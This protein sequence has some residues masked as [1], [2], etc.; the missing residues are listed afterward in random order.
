[1]ADSTNRDYA[2]ALIVL[3]SIYGG[4]RQLE[5]LGSLCEEYGFF[6]AFP[7]LAAAF[8]AAY[9]F[10][11]EYGEL[12]TAEILRR[13]LEILGREKGLAE[14]HLQS[15]VTQA[16]EWLG[17]RI[18]NDG[19][20][21]DILKAFRE[22][23]VC[24]KLRDDLDNEHLQKAVEGAARAIRSDPFQ[25]PQEENPFSNPG[26]YLA[27]TKPYPFGVSFLDLAMNGG[28]QLGETI[29]LVAPSGGGK[30]TIGLQIVERQVYEEQHVVYFATEQK[31]KGDLALRTFVLATGMTRADWS[32]DWNNIQPKARE[33]WERVREPWMKYFHFYDI[34]RSQ[35]ASIDALY[36]P[37]VEQIEKGNQPVFVIIDWWGD[38]RDA[39]IEA[40][41][42]RQ[43]SEAEIRRRSRGW[44]KEV[45]NK[46][47]E[48]RIVNFALHQLSGAAA[49]KSHERVQ[50]SHDAQEDRSFNNRMDF[51]F[52]LSRKAPNGDVTCRADKARRFR[53]ENFKLNLSGE[54]CR[55]YLQNMEGGQQDMVDQVL[56]KPEATDNYL[57]PPKKE[58]A[59]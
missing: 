9:G 7:A 51:A 28:A 8:E 55:F 21:Q 36:A 37:V 15:I 48:L 32:C 31:L 58:D 34:S 45:V 49:S 29:G 40:L 23:R 33:R 14:V 12:P 1:M 50:S 20:A 25:K 16:Q 38:V 53:N 3:Q 24:A 5:M 46:A 2:D 39:L 44:L 13:D 52:T 41:T 56:D 43:V 26:N 54:R 59:D 10:F 22:D 18:V 11:Q 27:T 4:A 17:K 42:E 35:P 30:T 19:P 57:P 47:S 6:E